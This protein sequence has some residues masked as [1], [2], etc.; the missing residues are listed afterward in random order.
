MTIVPEVIEIFVAPQS[1]LQLVVEPT[2][3]QVV[4]APTGIEGPPGPVGAASWGNING[5]IKEQTDLINLLNGKA[6]PYTE[7]IRGVD[8][9]INQLKKWTSSSKTTLLLTKTFNRVGG[10]LSSIVSVDAETGDTVTTTLTRS[11]GSLVAIEVI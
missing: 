1:E 6:Y 7:I 3:P 9:K 4:I 11:S 8:G 10:V 2:I 5:E